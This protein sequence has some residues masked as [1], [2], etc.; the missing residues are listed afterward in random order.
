M[1]Y[2]FI[3]FGSFSILLYG[4]QLFWKSPLSPMFPYEVRNLIAQGDINYAVDLLEW[5]AEHTWSN[6][7]Q[8]EALWEAAQIGLFEI[9]RRSKSGKFYTAMPGFGAFHTCFRGKCHAGFYVYRQTAEIIDT[10]LGKSHTSNTPHAQ[11]D[12][13]RIQELLELM[14]NWDKLI[15]PF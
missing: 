13:W 12:D 6:K 11:V 10:I 8:S 3:F 7:E 15:W 5:R 14:K 9:K 2:R 1:L 4:L